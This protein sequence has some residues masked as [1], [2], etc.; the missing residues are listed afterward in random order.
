MR[1]NVKCTPLLHYLAMENNKLNNIRDTLLKDGYTNSSEGTYRSAPLN[2]FCKR[3]TV[4][5]DIILFR[6]WSQDDF[7][8]GVCLRSHPKNFNI[9]Y[10]EFN[11][12]CN[13][14]HTVALFS[15]DT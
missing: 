10:L 14:I 3:I 11:Q 13:I 5:S 9:V 2:G 15:H 1:G 12:K 4:T 8:Y 6:A 7:E